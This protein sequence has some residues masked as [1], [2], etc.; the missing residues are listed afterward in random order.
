MAISFLEFEQPIAELE[1]KLEELSHLTHD[2]KV[3][4]EEEMNKLRAEAI[5]SAAC[6]T[7]WATLRRI[8]TE[9]AR[10]RSQ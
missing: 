3:N 6:A 9:R 8:S 1:A 10:G 5:V 2:G 7:I 4:I